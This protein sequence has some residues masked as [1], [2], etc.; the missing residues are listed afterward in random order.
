M[1]GGVHLGWGGN[2]GQRAD[3]ASEDVGNRGSYG[4]KMM[5]HCL[6]GDKGNDGGSPCYRGRGGRLCCSGPGYGS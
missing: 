5:T 1:G 4:G 2:F 3:S 6:G